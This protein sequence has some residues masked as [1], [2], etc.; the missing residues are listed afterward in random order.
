MITCMVIYSALV[1]WF[2]AGKKGKLPSPYVGREGKR[3]FL[4]LFF[5]NTI[6]MSLFVTDVWKHQNPEEV[7]RNSYGKGTRT[8]ELEIT[9]GNQLKQEPFELEVKERKYTRKEIQKI[10]KQVMEELDEMI[11]GDN[12]SLD[13]VEYDLNLV[14]RAEKYPIQIQ[15]ESDDYGVMNEEGEIRQEHT[16]EEGTLVEIRGTL[17]YEGEEALYVR[18]VMVYPRK[19]SAKEKLLSKIEE[20]VESESEKRKEK[21]SFLLPAEIDG[22]EIRWSRK[23][24]RRGYYVLILGCIS[25]GLIVALKKQNQRKDEKERKEQMITD[26]PEIVNKFALLLSTGMTVKGAWEKIVRNYETQKTSMGVRAAYEEMSCTYYEMKGGVTETEAYERF[27]KR[28]GI[29]IY[30]R[31]G[32]LLS[33]NLRKGTKGM[34]ELLKTESIQAFENRKSRARRLGEEASTK[35]LIPMFGML[36]VVLFIVVFPAF[37][38]IQI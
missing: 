33:Q 31:F 37:L 27:G 34:T 16:K 10:F 13:R 20:L 12:E 14:T 19:K 28:C 26:Y 35:L 5:T 8:E 23:K 17:S 18:N 11:L 6:A 4:I 38:S 25:A 3:I 7:Q 21:E 9:V 36:A 1:F 22:K 29:T 32:A 15:W 24:E 30:I 2:L